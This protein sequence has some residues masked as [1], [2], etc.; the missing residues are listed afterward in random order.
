MIYIISDLVPSECPGPELHDACLLIEGEVCHVDCARGLKTGNMS[1]NIFDE[2]QHL[3]VDRKRCFI[4]NVFL[5]S[6]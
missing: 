3:T 2:T 4:L 5:T 1:C 6:S